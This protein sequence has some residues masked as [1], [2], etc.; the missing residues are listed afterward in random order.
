[1][2]ILQISKNAKK[3]AYSR[4]RSCPY[5]GER[6]LQNTN[7]EYH[8][9]ICFF[10]NIRYS[11]ISYFLEYQHFT[12]FCCNFL[13]FREIFIKIQSKNDE[14]HLK[15]SK[16]CEN[17]QKI[18]QIFWQIF[19]KFLNLERCEGMQILQSSKNAK[20]CANSRYRSCPYREERALQSTNT[21]Y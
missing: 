2:Q 4:Y 8:S 11:Q 7:I 17:L 14:I 19:A 5:R 16:I 9:N 1:M 15:N 21:E 18:T 12:V 13:K 10:W 6:A 3:C 20:K